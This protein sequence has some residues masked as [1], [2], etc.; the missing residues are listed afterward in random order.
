ML[1]VRPRGARSLAENARRGD[2]RL[3]SSSCSSWFVL[4]AATAPRLVC[5]PI[6]GRLADR[7]RFWLGGTARRTR[8]GKASKD[9]VF[10]IGP[11]TF[12][13]SSKLL[14][15][16]E[17]NR[18]AAHG[19]G[20]RRGETAWIITDENSPLDDSPLVS[21]ALPS[22]D[23][24]S[25]LL[26]RCKDGKTEVAVSSTGFINCGPDVRVIYRTAQE[27]PVETQSIQPSA[28]LRRR[29]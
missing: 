23:D 25:H 17:G 27:Q 29:L 20:D 7:R 18:G 26:M 28:R 22:S 19:E 24:R 4:S 9:A 12:R 13:P 11:Y 6:G 21:A 3:T 2:Q 1:S 16:P 15:N 8:P 14:L 5:G 10:T